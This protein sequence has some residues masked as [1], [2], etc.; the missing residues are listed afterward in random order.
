MTKRIAFESARKLYRDTA[1]FWL[2]N[3]VQTDSQTVEDVP[4]LL[5][6]P[7]HREGIKGRDKP[8]WQTIKS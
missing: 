4:A 5:D 8:Q 1:R 3:V 6:W 2:E 7:S